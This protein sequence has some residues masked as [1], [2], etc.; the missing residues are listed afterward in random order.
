MKLRVSRIGEQVTTN[1]N[2]ILTLSAK[3]TVKSLFG[4]D[5]LVERKFNYALPSNDASSI[6]L[7]QEIEFNSGNYSFVDRSNVNEETGET[8]TSTWIHEKIRMDDEE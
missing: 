8:M 4:T 5:K 3:Q 2:I 6:K 1:D 7:D